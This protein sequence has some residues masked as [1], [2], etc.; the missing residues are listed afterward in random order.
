MHQFRPTALG[1]AGDARALL[2]GVLCAGL[3]IG[4]QVVGKALRDALLL[5]TFQAERL[6][7]MMLITALVGLPLVLVVARGMARFGPQRLVPAL[8][9]GSALLHVVEYWL[10]SRAPG[11]AVVLVYLDVSL[12]GAI[13]ISGLWS[14]IGER[15]DPHAARRAMSSIAVGA[16][17]GGLA[18][19]LLA[20][21]LSSAG[22][23]QALL[24]VLAFGAA[25]SALSVSWLGRAAGERPLAPTA[26]ERAAAHSRSG[27]AHLRN[28]AAVVVVTGFSA[29][30]VDYVFKAQAARSL[31]SGAE[32][33][34][35]FALAYTATSVGTIALQLLLVRRVLER[36]GIGGTLAV[37]PATVLGLALVSLA[38]PGLWPLVVLRAA[39][40]TL[41]NSFFRSAYEP[42]YTPVPAGQR[43][44]AKTIIDVAADRLGEVVAS[45]AILGALRF[46]AL[47]AG[48]LALGAAIAGAGL[49]LWL[50]ARLQRG[51]VAE[52]ALSLRDG[53]LTLTDDQVSDAT[54]RLA[55]SQ[56]QVEI[57]RV[58]LLEQVSAFALRGPGSLRGQPALVESVGELVSGDP[59]RATR[60]LS[61]GPLD[62]KLV[63]F[64][65]PWLE[66]D[67]VAESA[68]VALTAVAGSASGQLLDALLDPNLPLKLR[69]RIPRILGTSADQRNARGLMDGV[70]APEFVLRQRSALALAEL[71]RSD[72]LLRPRRARVLEAARSE[73]ALAD[74]SVAVERRLRHVFVLLGLALDREALELAEQALFGS[75]EKLR[76]TAL[77]YLENVLPDE[78]REA[79][80]REL[81]RRTSVRPRRTADG[82]HRASLAN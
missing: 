20:R 59:T 57:D 25:L 14:V 35:F 71:V 12:L 5:G 60:L 62:L 54:T 36:V 16:A 53:S 8:L 32:L 49:S 28:L 11:A 81:R 77:E 39:E 29:A 41:Q 19:G 50:A 56:T 55:L 68:T 2:L 79:L 46:A 3:L 63:A 72:P 78:V 6:P 4:Q 47:P 69:Q 27:S 22:G 51:Y 52:L 61:R 45:V 76:G 73:L 9:V 21:R 42:L 70:F 34:S 23:P 38:L 40:A 58:R 82:G 1:S 37:L 30:L 7:L 33:V 74:A 48:A 65:L 15:F 43:R 26:L 13:T 10:L 17:V 75:D 24:V 64:A 31:A 18:G 67:E 66:V 80:L 44:A